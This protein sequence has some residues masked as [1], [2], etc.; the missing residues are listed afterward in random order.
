MWYPWHG[1]EL[2]VLHAS[3][4]EC[5]EGLL[6]HLLQRQQPMAGR[7]AVWADPRVSGFNGPCAAL[8]STLG[9]AG[10]EITMMC[11]NGGLG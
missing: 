2:N 11:E 10:G 5:N 7:A 9:T 1:T 3:I 4:E 6:V 8:G